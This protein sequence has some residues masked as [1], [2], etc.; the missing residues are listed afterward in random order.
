MTEYTAQAEITGLDWLGKDIENRP[1]A[2]RRVTVTQPVDLLIRMDAAEFAG[3]DLTRPIT[4][5]QQKR[6]VNE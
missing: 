3:L 1:I 2:G 4:I 5:T 6:P